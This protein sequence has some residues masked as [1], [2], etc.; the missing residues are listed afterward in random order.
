M[1]GRER[2][3][4]GDHIEIGITDDDFRLVLDRDRRNQTIVEAADCA[5]PATDGSIACL[6]SSMRT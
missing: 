2:R 1:S 6:V 4:R 3:N 5:S